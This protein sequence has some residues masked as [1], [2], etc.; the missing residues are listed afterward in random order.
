MNELAMS[1]PAQPRSVPPLIELKDV[2]LS[3]EGRKILSGISFAADARRIGIVGRNGSGKTTLAHVMAGL[4]PAGT[5]T[6]RIGGVDVSASREAALGQIGLLYQNPDNQISFPTVGAELAAGLAAQGQ[7]QPVVDAAVRAILKRFDKTHWADASVQA[8][9]QGQRQL[10]CLMAVLAMAP[11]V[12]VLDEPFSGLDIPTSAHLRRVL[13]G[14]DVALVHITHDP[15]AVRD[16]ERVL[17]IEK[18]CVI[19]EGKA[20][21]VL[22]AFQRRMYEIGAGDDLS[23]LAG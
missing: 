8:L 9:S 1:I 16:C 11:K 21:P 20:A 6:V 3:A 23:D 22:A 19:R 18:G 4:V 14:L 13:A 10:V 12:I 17:W 2:S 5:G 7:R 15:D